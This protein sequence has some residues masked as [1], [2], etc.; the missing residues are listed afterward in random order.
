MTRPLF[1]AATTGVAPGKASRAVLRRGFLITAL[2]LSHVCVFA[3]EK[4]V[5]AHYMTDMVPRTDRPLSRWINP[6]LADPNGS[7]ATLGGIH[8]TVPMAALHLKDADLTKA[9]DFEIRA[10][11][12]LGLDGF[13]FYYPLTDN[14]RLLTHAYNPIIREFIRLSDQR[15][16]GFRIS[17]CLSHPFT[18]KPVPE[19]ERIAKW[20]EPVRQLLADT[21]KSKAWLR[22]VR[23][24]LLL[25]LW[26]GDQLAE[27]VGN[28]AYN[29]EQMNR[30]GAAYRKFSKAVGTPID[31][32]YQVRRP[33]IDP[34]YVDAILKNF[35]AVWGWTASEENIEFWD[36]LAKR[37]KQA[38]VVYTQT[39]Y[40]DYYTSKVYRKGKHDYN[41][42]TTKQAIETGVEGLERH[43]R[44]TDLAQ[45]QIK[46]LQRAIKHDVP[47][48]NYATWNDYP[49]G[50]HLAPEAAHNFGPSLLLRHFKRQ[51]KTGTQTVERD[52]AIVFF[53]KHRHDAKPRF[54][55]ALEIKSANKDVANE[56][57]IE[58][59]TLL[60]EPAECFI[61]VRSFGIVPAG[62]Q[63][64]S[65]PSAPG[66]ARVRI[67]R[68]GKT[69]ISFETP[70]A[71]TEKPLRTD[72][73]TYSYS[74]AYDR[75]FKKLFPGKEPPLQ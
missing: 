12:Q 62:L 20:S 35:H 38:G 63:V 9:V 52:E 27:G 6:E 54:Q 26:V 43:Y 4:L 45:T 34:P 61:N 23:G 65:I 57:R 69:I 31:Y 30:V 73:L 21:S 24:S 67:E 49:E 15:Y 17:I 11:R 5:I 10:A 8:Q 25:Y 68:E 70:V 75:E 16:P 60:T 46:L 56:D 1:S 55:I 71:I 48:I 39:V 58:L 18:G 22:T 32:V 72:R 7:T 42:L 64:N 36:Y 37:C 51:W 50:H 2:L 13:Q 44:V 40:P 19:A 41:F 47:I 74:S 33:E 28:L 29:R 53:K 3:A 14:T 66:A 59:V